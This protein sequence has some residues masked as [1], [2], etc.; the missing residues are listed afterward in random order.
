MLRAIILAIV[1]GYAYA[2]PLQESAA[3]R[4]EPASNLTTL[5]DLAH[6][7][8]TEECFPEGCMPKGTPVGSSKLCC[9][10]GKGTLGCPGPVHY[11][12]G[13]A[14]PSPPTPGPCYRCSDGDPAVPQNATLVVGGAKV[15]VTTQLKISV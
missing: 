6:F 3:I 14:P 5:Q 7:N 13:T 10:E 15:Q 9:A 1:A 2:A 11:R 4:A 12:C 8:R